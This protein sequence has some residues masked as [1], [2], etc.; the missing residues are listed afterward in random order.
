MRYHT[1]PAPPELAPW[2]RYCWSLESTTAGDA[3]HRLTAEIGANLV[4]IL[5][6]SFTEADG[7]TAPAAHLAGAVTRSA[8]MTGH[9]P[10]ALFGVYL[11]PWSVEALF[12]STAAD[13]HDR[14]TALHVLWGARGERLGAA[15]GAAATVEQRIALLRDAFLAAPHAPV[16]DVL[17]TVVRGMLEHAAPPDLDATVAA[18]GLARRQFER[19]FKRCTGF[20]PA[21]FLRIVR[22]QRTYRMLENGTATTLTDVAHAA[23]YF[24]QSH[25]IR[26][27]KRF[28]GLNPKAYFA[29]AAEKADNFLRLPGA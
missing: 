8:D 21:L 12:G 9:G 15:V 26:D 29:H 18:S 27:F 16:D 4:F 28:S 14:F 1:H 7:S 2:V 5:R 11:W 25:F 10:F 17:N 6:G 19:R 13:Q 3:P 24:D 22:F 20:S 23:G